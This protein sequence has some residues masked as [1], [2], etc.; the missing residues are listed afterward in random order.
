[1]NFLLVGYVNYMGEIHTTRKMNVN[2]L[3]SKIRD[4]LDHGKM[5]IK[6]IFKKAAG[7]ILSVPEYDIHTDVEAREAMIILYFLSA[8]CAMP[9]DQESNWL[10][11]ISV[12]CKR[13]CDSIIKRGKDLILKT[14][15]EARDE[16][17]SSLDLCDFIENNIWRKLTHTVLLHLIIRMKQ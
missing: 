12:I 7:D 8:H 6:N 10:C 5:R 16:N 4:S 11:D 13:L 1:V 3:F 14:I 2:C 9:D 15:K 17:W